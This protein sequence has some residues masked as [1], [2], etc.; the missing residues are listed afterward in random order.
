MP[1]QCN[2]SFSAL[3]NFY[4][5][6]VQIN[7]SA[8]DLRLATRLRVCR[9]SLH[10]HRRGQVDNPV[11]ICQFKRESSN[12]FLYTAERHTLLNLVEHCLPILS[13]CKVFQTTYPEPCIVCK[14]HLCEWDMLHAF[15]YTVIEAIES[16]FDSVMEHP[17]SSFEENP[18]D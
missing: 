6:A 15:T 10:L 2:R 17:F 18:P 13:K 4:I 14:K 1:Q 8:N 3:L 7:I 12:Y 5:K 16:K 9:S 11:C